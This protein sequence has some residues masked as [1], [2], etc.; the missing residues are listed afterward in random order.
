MNWW[1]I[2]IRENFLQGSM[3]RLHINKIW[4]VNILKPWLTKQWKEIPSLY[5]YIY[6]YIYILLLFYVLAKN[7]TYNKEF[8]SL[9]DRYCKVSLDS[10]HWH[11]NLLST[12]FY[13]GHF[14]VE[15]M[16]FFL[17]LLY[18]WCLPFMFCSVHIFFLRLLYACSK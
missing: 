18:G 9:F 3:L 6:I 7:K 8:W 14:S 5:I 12:F 15:V 2:W 10:K 13:V 1:K 4:Q 16:I 17:F 11:F